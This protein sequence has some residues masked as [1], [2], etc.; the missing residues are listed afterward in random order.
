MDTFITQQKTATPNRY[1]FLH[2]NETDSYGHKYGWG[3]AIWNSQVVIVDT[4]LGKIFKL[5]EQDVP[6]MNGHT[7]IILTADH[8]NQDNPVT[9]ADRYS[10][11]FFVW[12]PRVPAGADLYVLNAS[13]RRVASVYPMTTYAG[14]QPI[15]NAEAN[16]VALSLLGLGPITG[17]TFNY[18]QD[19]K[20]TLPPT[21]FITSITSDGHGNLTI[22]GTANGSGKVV[23]LKSTSL[24]APN[25]LPVKTNAVIWGVPF[26]ST[27]SQG[28]DLWPFSECKANRPNAFRAA[29]RFSI[30]NRAPK[31]R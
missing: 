17:S 14:I 21:P 8:G 15:R 22:S 10:V 20:V 30:R 7:A 23:L 6:A 31:T 4:M 12:G 1:A 29:V 16:N 28:A 3:S 13:N 25:W 24:A 9:G 27:V 11:P 18:A 5:I 26:G 2:I 19:L